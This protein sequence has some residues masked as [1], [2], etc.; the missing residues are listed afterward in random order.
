MFAQLRFEFIPDLQE[1][2]FARNLG[3][4]AHDGAEDR[5][6]RRESDVPFDLH[7]ENR[8]VTL[9]VVRIDD[10]VIQRMSLGRPLEFHPIDGR[11]R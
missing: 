9:C 3:D 6:A 7:F 4:L 10:D 2:R 5:V 8:G 1:L 11:S